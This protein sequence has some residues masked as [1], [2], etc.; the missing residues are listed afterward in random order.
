LGG[1]Q[2]GT[3]YDPGRVF[4]RPQVVQNVRSQLEVG[5]AP[6]N[7]K[8]GTASASSGPSPCRG[9]RKRVG[10]RR[11]KKRSDRK[12]GRSGMSLQAWRR[13]GIDSGRYRRPGREMSLD[14]RSSSGFP[15]GGK[16]VSR[17][18]PRLGERRVETC[19]PSPRVQSSARD[20]V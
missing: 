7:G 9:E 11:R 2:H 3:L 8:K 5:N 19:E 1:D 6:S 4:S 16:A 13:G 15:G 12:G 14:S 10:I 20:R 18:S 17:R